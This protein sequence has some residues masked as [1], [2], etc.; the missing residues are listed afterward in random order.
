M[1]L[2]VETHSYFSEDVYLRAVF[3]NCEN[4]I[5]EFYT[6]FGFLDFTLTMEQD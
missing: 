6:S 5:E 4:S 1:K 2:I 3:F